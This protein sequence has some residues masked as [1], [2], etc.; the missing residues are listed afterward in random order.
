MNI[1]VLTSAFSPMHTANSKCIDNIIKELSDLHQFLVISSTQCSTECSYASVISPNQIHP[2]KNYFYRCLKFLS[3]IMNSNGFDRGRFSYFSKKLCTL[4]INVDVIIPVCFPVESL[5]AAY[6]FKRQNPD[7]I[8]IPYLLDLFSTS[9]TAH[10]FSLIQKYK[11]NNNI[12]FESQFL[13]ISASILANPPWYSHIQEFFP[14]YIFKTKEI[15]YPF[16]AK[17]D[18]QNSNKYTDAN[19]NPTAKAIVYSGTLDK[20]NRSPLK[21]LNIYSRALSLHDKFHLHLIHRGDCGSVIDS[22]T[23]K[24]SLNIFNH[25]EMESAVASS[26]VNNAEILLFIGNIDFRQTPSKIFEYISTG[27]P[28][29]AFL[30]SD[31]DPIISLLRRYP[32]FCIIL[33]SDPSDVSAR[34]IEEFLEKMQGK[35]VDFDLLEK[36][37]FKSTPH[38]CANQ[39][40]ISLNSLTFRSDDVQK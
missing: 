14:N 28:I 35:F 5:A 25:G 33:E 10:T 3:R 15:S 40:K 27:K 38:Y 13:D 37:F 19:Q 30:F 29:L 11:F 21:F 31:Q 32:L 16:I 26:F 7:V 2:K 9:S 4:D 34:R 24:N 18:N 20:R 39:L 8:I 17:L 36:T 12:K 6:E 1:V 23:T 22:F